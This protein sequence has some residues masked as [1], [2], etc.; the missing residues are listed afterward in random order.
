MTPPCSRASKPSSLVASPDD[1]IFC[2]YES[3][4][5][6]EHAYHHNTHIALARFSLRWI[7][8]GPPASLAQFRVVTALAS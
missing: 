3:G 1:T 4:L 7:Q 2:L 8:D 5:W 6:G